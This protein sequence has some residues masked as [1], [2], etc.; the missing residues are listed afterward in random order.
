MKKDAAVIVIGAGMAGLAAACELAR[1][2][3]AVTVLEARERLGGRVF[4]QHDPALSTPI[5]LGAEFIHGRPSEILRPL[6]EAKASITEVDGDSWC[7]TRQHLSPCDFTSEVDSILDQMD[8][9]SP[10]ESFQAFLDR[11]FPNPKTEQQREARQRAV[12]Y[13]SGFN[14]ADPALV[15]VHWLVQEMR[16]EERSEGDRS[17]RSANGYDDL[18]NVFRRQIQH[19]DVAV[20]T[21]TV[22]ETVQWKAGEVKV[23][24]RGQNGPS[25]FEAPRILVTLSVSLLKASG[26]EAGV[27]QFV[28]ALPQR[29]T[30]ALDHIEMGK[31]IRI[32]LRFREHFWETIVPPGGKNKNLSNLSFL[33]SQDEWF[34]TWWTAMPER[35][36]IITGWAPFRCGERLSGQSE[37]FVVER[38]LQT[39]SGLLGV[40]LRELQGLLEKAYV[41]D[42]Q[43]DPFSRGAYSYG[44][45]GAVRAQRELGTPVDNTLFFAGEATDTAGHTGTVHGAIA[46]G[47]RAAREILQAIE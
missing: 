14:A 23:V 44:K 36:P 42:W 45:V 47:G 27:V 15:G 17:F 28:P 32:V 29:K 10:D 37:S 24:A 2:G 13:V 9:S 1:A 7:V 30:E 12:S 20:H 39:L 41:H 35:S 26:G 33:F 22:V 16:A 46:T 8:D 40:S 6:A 34:P 5:E 4:T 43:S 18:L 19:Y 21:E 3:V 31:V 25:L 11:R 38:S